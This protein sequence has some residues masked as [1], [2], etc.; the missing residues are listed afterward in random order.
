MAEALT[1]NPTAVLNYIGPEFPIEKICSVPFIE[2]SP[3]VVKKHIKAV[4]KALTPIPEGEHAALAKNCLTRVQDTEA[5]AKM[6]AKLVDKEI[7]ASG[8][9]A[10]WEDLEAHDAKFDKLR[11]SL[12]GG[13][14]LNWV[15]IASQLRPLMDDPHGAKIDNALTNV[16][17]RHP[18]AI[19]PYFGHGFDLDRICSVGHLQTSDRV[20][21]RDR[22]LKVLSPLVTGPN[23]DLVKKCS[24]R[25]KP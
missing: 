19:L 22:L 20:Q 17:E 16:L 4:E 18:E 11:N 25:L 6:T 13:Q 15:R 5:V 10:V 3:A 1:K 14:D 12:Y 9:K 2:P 8:A 23:S 24:Q 21:T 7:S